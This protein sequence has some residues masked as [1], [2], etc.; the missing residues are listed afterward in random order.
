[1]VGVA[2]P[3]GAPNLARSLAVMC[4]VWRGSERASP[5]PPS[6]GY[7]ITNN[8]V[9]KRLEGI[10]TCVTDRSPKSSILPPPPKS[11]RMLKLGGRVLGI[12]FIF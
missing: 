11:K 12:C 10:S 9:L 7:Y 5:P 2:Q 4:K 1:M 3:A 8:S 6:H